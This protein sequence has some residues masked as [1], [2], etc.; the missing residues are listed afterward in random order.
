MG[1]GD[2]FDALSY[3]RAIAVGRM[4]SGVDIISS[5]HWIELLRRWLPIDLPSLCFR[6]SHEWAVT[7]DQMGSEGVIISNA[8]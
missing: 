4:V 5:V 7:V 1:F 3:E 8:P 6:I 2:Q